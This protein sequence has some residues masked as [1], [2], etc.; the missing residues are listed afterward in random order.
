MISISAK[1][2]IVFMKNSDLDIS[3]GVLQKQAYTLSKCVLL[4]VYS[5]DNDDIKLS[6]RH[7]AQI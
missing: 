5:V 7:I 1:T 3:V 4:S 6:K 2:K